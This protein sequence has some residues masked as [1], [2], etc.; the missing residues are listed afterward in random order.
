MGY[1]K[2]S[3]QLGEKESTLGARIRKWKKHQMIINLLWSGGPHKISQRRVMMRMVREQPRTTLQELVDNLKAAG[4]TVTNMTIS[5]TLRCKRQKSCSTS[6]FPKLKEA[7][8]KFAKEHLD[9]SE[10]GLEKVLWSDETKMEL[11]D[12]NSTRRV[13]RKKSRLRPQENHPTH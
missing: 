4:T 10:E 7:R 9:G 1:K 12:I 5:N 8:L 6:K 2:I 11:F 13:W 3:K